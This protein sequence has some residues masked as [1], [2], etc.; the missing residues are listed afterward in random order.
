MGRFDNIFSGGTNPTSG[1]RFD[2]IFGNRPTTIPT[3]IQAPQETPTNYPGTL[4]TLSELKTN[5]LSIRKPEGTSLT[6]KIYSLLGGNKAGETLKNAFT[7]NL[8]KSAGAVASFTS[9]RPTSEKVGKTMEALG[10]AAGLLFSPI[11]AVFSAANEV[12]VL[13]TISRLISLPFTAVGEAS[14]D[15]FNKTLDTIPEN[16]L[17]KSSKEQIRQG[18]SEIAS[19]AGQ[20]ALGKV[21]EVAGVK[22]KKAKTD[23]SIN[24]DVFKTL[25]EKYGKEDAQKIL[26]VASQ[27]AIEPS[28]APEAKGKFE[29]TFKE[30]PPEPIKEV[31]S[32]V[33]QQIE[34]D[35]IAKDL[36]KGFERL[37]TY[38]PTEVKVQAELAKGVIDSGVE[39]VTK[40]LRGEA[41]LPT[42]LKGSSFGAAVTR[43]IDNIKNTSKDVASDLVYEL[44]NSKIV[45]DIS[46]AAQSMRL[47]QEAHPDSFISR[48]RDVK[49]YKE[50]KVKDAPK[51]KAN[52]VNKLKEGSK[53]PKDALDM[54]KLDKFINEIIC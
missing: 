29:N 1:G 40:I 46:E 34:A 7:T 30:R 28:V 27:K 4:Q 33:A 15:L 16:I 11:S 52:L 5:P 9:G 38:E 25:A 51:Q 6:D 14:S 36:T 21:S 35:A 32:G 48:L 26:E 44:A 37:S 8:E 3:Q 45:S 19:L 13:G 42:G 24:S 2:N 49:T 23:I 54:S 47:W 17:S 39:N 41:E 50:S 12:P 31:P 20:I 18:G 10:G 43:F 53:I 22:F